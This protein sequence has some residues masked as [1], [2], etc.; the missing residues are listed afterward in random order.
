MHIYTRSD[1]KVPGMELY[2]LAYLHD[3]KTHCSVC[4]ETPPE[5]CHKISSCYHKAFC[6]E[7][8]ICQ[9]LSNAFVVFLTNLSSCLINRN[10][11]FAFLCEI[12][13]NK[14]SDS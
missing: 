2:T 11:V 4:R 9:G 8:T 10:S 13:E 14:Y 5:C 6:R 12:R 3:G 7:P 1:P